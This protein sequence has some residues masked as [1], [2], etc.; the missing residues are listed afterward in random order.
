MVG[1]GDELDEIVV[2][3]QDAAAVFHREL[4]GHA[5]GGV[6]AAVRGV[7]LD[8]GVEGAGPVLA[9]DVLD[10]LVGVVVDV[11]DGV[12]FEAVVPAQV[13]VLAQRVAEEQAPAHG[14]L[15]VVG[16]VVELVVEAQAHAE[17]RVVVVGVPEGGRVVGRPGAD[18]ACEAQ[19]VAHAE[20]V[21]L[22]DLPR[23]ED[24]GVARIADA[25]RE[26]TRGLLLDLDP[27]VEL[28][29]RL[30]GFGGDLDGLEVVELVQPGVG[31]AQAGAA[32]EVPVGQAHL[33]ADDVVPGL[34]VAL[35]EHAVDGHLGASRHGVGDAQGVF[36]VV[37][38][39]LHVG[40]G[41]G[42]AEIGIVLGQPL[43]VAAHDGAVEVFVVRGQVVHGHDGAEVFGRAD[44]LAG[45]VHVG[46]LVARALVDLEGHGDARFRVRHLG[47]AHLGVQEPAVA[48]VGL[49]GGG[50]AVQ[51]LFAQ[52]ARAG[53]PGEQ[54]A[55]GQGQLVLEVVGV[56]LVGALDDDV[57]DVELVAFVDEDIQSGALGVG[58]VEAVADLGVIVAVLA[59]KFPDLAHVVGQDFGVQDGAGLGG[60]GGQQ[61]V[62]VELFGAF[63]GDGLDEGLFLDADD[64][65]FAFGCFVHGNFDVI[66]VSEFIEAFEFGI[67]GL[68]VVD[69]A[70]LDLEAHEHDVVV[71]D[72]VA[73]HVDGGDAVLLLEAQLDLGCGLL[74]GREDVDDPFLDHEKGLGLAYAVGFDQAGV[75][76]DGLPDLAEAAVD[77]VSGAGQQ[78]HVL[79][80]VQVQE[81][82]ALFL[83]KAD[84]LL[85]GNDRETHA[86]Q[87]LAQQLGQ[88]FLQVGQVRPRVDGE[89]QDDDLAA[90]LREGRSGAEKTEDKN[91]KQ[92]QITFHTILR[93]EA[94]WCGACTGQ[95]QHC[96]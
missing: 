9:L 16:I 71:E 15:V 60:D 58:L 6:D 54:A 11:L 40:L 83:Q 67:D 65:A 78:G 39:E 18:G 75:Q 68:G 92:E 31:P 32:E 51:D 45:E 8:G 35:D 44:H 84:G 81:F 13:G 49:K 50:V 53:H 95:V 4:M 29:G 93:N 12:L 20:E 73:A 37:A 26:L 17:V 10:D 91:Q 48:V 38:V 23:E 7:A 46:D 34:G 36:G 94:P 96:G 72:L 41:K 21:A 47:L 5:L 62:G 33:A 63:H 19:L 25:G 2:A 80:H 64:Q 1:V 90:R 30:G 42:V 59:V 24:L 89:R 22:Q 66:E 82:D 79:G 70:G 28:V 87:A 86:C 55:F 88:A 76:A 43:Q 57:R 61:V 74:D 3:A 77:G 27:Q 69:V 85:F 56:E 14:L 52:D